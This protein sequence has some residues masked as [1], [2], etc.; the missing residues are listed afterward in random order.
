VRLDKG[1]IRRFAA[2]ALIEDAAS[3]D[4]TT[5][6][7]IEAG[8][9]VEA[10]IVA[11]EKGVVCGLP[12]VL[13]VFKGFDRHV[14]VVIR[15]GEGARLSSGDTILGLSGRARSILS[16]ERVALNFLAY[17]SGIASMTNAAARSV[18]RAGVVIL[19]TRKTTPLLRTLEK[20]AVAV[21]GGRNH[22]FN[23][24]DQYLVKDNHILVLKAKGGLDVLRER[25]P[26]IPFEIE[27][28]S[29]EELKRVATLAPQIVM[30]DNFTP[31]EVR[32]AVAWL[33]KAYPDRDRRP[34]IELSGGITPGTIARYAIRGVDFISLGALTHSAR[35][36]DLSLEITKVR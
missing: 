35:A 7:F 28:E 1:L 34:L 27:V 10:R 15:K 8:V 20:Y 23:L 5:N 12:L 29:L 36:L 25:R 14:K 24:A 19:D 4:I 18:G 3:G 16:C 21:G 30:L 9:R 2:E 6:D 31:F 11:R 26:G 22:R 17:L 32:R 33:T 13:E